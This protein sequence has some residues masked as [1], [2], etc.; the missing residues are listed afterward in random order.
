MRAGGRI[1]MAVVGWSISKHPGLRLVFL[2]IAI[3]TDV[4]FFSGSFLFVIL[5]GN[6]RALCGKGLL[7]V[8]FPERSSPRTDTRALLPRKMC[9]ARRLASVVDERRINLVETPARV[10][11]ASCRA[12]RCCCLN[13]DRAG[14]VKVIRLSVIGFR[15]IP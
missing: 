6:A 10:T 1:V 7:F 9:R 13:K 11:P 15:P 8:C 3:K 14:W 4:P 2:D 5:R 12:L